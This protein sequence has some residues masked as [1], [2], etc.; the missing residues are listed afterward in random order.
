M[1][2]EKALSATEQKGARAP[3]AA[4][5]EAL[6]RFLYEHVE[7]LEEL[8]V[9]AAVRSRRPSGAELEQVVRTTGLPRASVEEALGRLVTTGLLVRSSGVVLTFAYAEH[10]HDFTV[11]LDRAI[12]EYQRNPV[13]VMGFMTTN[14]IERVRG[15]ARRR[16]G[17]SLRGSEKTKP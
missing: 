13:Q 10:E 11:L 8:A 17:E 9:V 12:A 5:Q 2:Q 16:F 14:A 1:A 7:N 6:R 4:D 15:A 3:A